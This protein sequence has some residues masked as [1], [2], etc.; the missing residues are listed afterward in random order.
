VTLNALIH[1]NG[2]TVEP[3]VG[4]AFLTTF[5]L[6]VSHRTR[7]EALAESPLLGVH[8]RR[9]SRTLLV[10]VLFAA[11]SGQ[12]LLVV[13]TLEPVT[14]VLDTWHRRALLEA[15]FIFPVAL[16]LVLRVSSPWALAGHF[17]HVGVQ[18]F[19]TLVEAVLGAWLDKHVVVNVLLDVLVMHLHGVAVVDTHRKALV[20]P[21]L[22]DHVEHVISGETS[23]T[24]EADSFSSELVE[25]LPWVVKLSAVSTAVGLVTFTFVLGLLAV[26]VTHAH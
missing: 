26:S 3:V 10:S 9:T 5:E 17:V 22:R 18:S 21:S 25:L 11:F 1:R 15:V 14:V 13:S 4:T 19:R 7:S 24:L 8:G 12:D 2:F 20:L 23:M 16:S 6:W